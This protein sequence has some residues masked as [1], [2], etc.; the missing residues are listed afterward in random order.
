[1]YKAF[2]AWD[3]QAVIKAQIR[4]QYDTD[5][6]AINHSEPHLK[7]CYPLGK[8][9]LNVFLFVCLFVLYIFTIYY[10]MKYSRSPWYN[11]INVRKPFL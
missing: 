6:L 8:T 7:L 4:K 2:E 11:E 9:L 1:M 10:S 5:S 3:P